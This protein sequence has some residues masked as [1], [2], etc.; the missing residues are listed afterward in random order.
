MRFLVAHRQWSAYAAGALVLATGGLFA[1]LSM[2]L[3]VLESI[4]KIIAIPIIF[5]AGIVILAYG[6]LKRKL[7]RSYA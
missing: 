1:L 2:L 5:S 4:A 3:I 6:F 7:T